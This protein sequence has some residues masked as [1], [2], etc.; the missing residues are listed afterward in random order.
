[1]LLMPGGFVITLPAVQR[2]N[3]RLLWSCHYFS[4]TF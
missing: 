4:E 2:R 3:T 1:M